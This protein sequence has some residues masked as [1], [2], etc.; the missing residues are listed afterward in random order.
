MRKTADGYELEVG[1][2][3]FTYPLESHEVALMNNDNILYKKTDSQGYFG[4]TWDQAYKYSSN[5]PDYNVYVENYDRELLRSILK[6]KLIQYKAELITMQ[7][8]LNNRWAFPELPHQL[9]KETHEKTFECVS[10]NI[11]PWISMIGQ[12]EDLIKKFKIVKP[13]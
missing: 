3:F 12:V 9:K 5:L 8:F 2:L 1:D 11:D 4:C 7:E 13:H 10:E 6:S